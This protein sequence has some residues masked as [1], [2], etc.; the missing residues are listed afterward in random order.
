MKRRGHRGVV[1][2]AAALITPLV[3]LLLSPPAGA[4]GTPGVAAL[5]VGLRSHGL[6]AGPVDGIAGARTARGVRSSPGL[7]I[8]SC[9]TLSRSIEYLTIGKRWPSGNGSTKWS[10]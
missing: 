2:A 6:Y 1:G 7:Q 9:A 3:T 4:I 8:P 5:Q 10:L